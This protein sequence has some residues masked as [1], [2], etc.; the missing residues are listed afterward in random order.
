MYLV[1]KNGHF[2]FFLILVATLLTIRASVSLV[3]ELND[4]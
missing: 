1:V 2:F 3:D 4:A